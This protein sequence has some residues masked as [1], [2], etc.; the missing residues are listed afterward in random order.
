MTK[1]KSFENVYGYFK[2]YLSMIDFII[3]NNIKFYKCIVNHINNII[4][5]AIYIYNNIDIY[6]K[7]NYFV[8]NRNEYV[9][10]YF[11]IVKYCDILNLNKNEIENLKIQLLNINKSFSFKIGRFITYIPRI[12]RD[13]IRKMLN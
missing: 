5:N 13:C 6:E 8:L 2:C 11:Y 12:V 4:N 9:K 7:N 10:F 1:K 3:S